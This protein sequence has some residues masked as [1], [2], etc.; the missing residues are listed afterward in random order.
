MGTHN[1]YLLKAKGTSGSPTE[2]AQG[3]ESIH[4][5]RGGGGTESANMHRSRERL[6]VIDH[7][8]TGTRPKA[9]KGKVGRAG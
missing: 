2:S 4:E 1:G 9:G 7:S 8:F 6:R 5:A 3:T